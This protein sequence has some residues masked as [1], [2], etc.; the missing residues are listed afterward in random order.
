M[1]RFRDE[2]DPRCEVAINS[3][4]RLQRWLRLVLPELVPTLGGEEAQSTLVN[5]SDEELFGR[6][7]PA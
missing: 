3:P 4:Q 1:T 6:K 7:V 5:K 2:H